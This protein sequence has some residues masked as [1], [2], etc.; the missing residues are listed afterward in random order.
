MKKISFLFLVLLAACVPTTR[1]LPPDTPIGYPA[2][3]RTLFD[4]TLQELTAAYVPDQ[5][6]RRTFSITEADPET[7]LI[8]AVR[9]ERGESVDL[10]Y[11]F[12]GYEY[13]DGDGDENGDEDSHDFPYGLGFRLAIP[14]PVSPTLRTVITIVVRP[15]GQGASLIYSTQG[16][17]GTSSRDAERLMRL[18]VSKLDA[19]FMA[20]STPMQPLPATP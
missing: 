15:Q 10:N 13:R 19:R 9:N 16:P 12:P 1:Y 11:R 17:D 5:L 14:V 4:A 8:T 18:V 6:S 3:Y 20:S 7:G 2:T